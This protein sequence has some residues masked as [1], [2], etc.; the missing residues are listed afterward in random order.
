LADA[1]K[2]DVREND[3]GALPIIKDGRKVIEMITDRDVCM[4]AAMKG[5]NPSAISVEEI[6]TSQVYAAKPEGEYRSGIARRC[7]T[8]GSK[9]AGYQRRWRVG[10]HLVY[11]MTLCFTPNFLMAPR[12]AGVDYTDVM[13]TYQTICQHRV[14]TMLQA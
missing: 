8:S 4:A 14:P 10:R 1:A 9:A 6:M 2:T 11:K 3:C 13:K 5:R 7:G 12:A